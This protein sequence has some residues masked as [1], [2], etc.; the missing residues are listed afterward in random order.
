MSPVRHPINQ[1][2]VEVE[3]L[4]NYFQVEVEALFKYFQGLALWEAL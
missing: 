4:Y 3:A 2:Q 1:L